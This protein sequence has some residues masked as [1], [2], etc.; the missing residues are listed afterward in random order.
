MSGIPSCDISEARGLVASPADIDRLAVVIGCSSA[1]SGL[2]PFY[3]SAESA[4]AGVG[5]GDAVDTLCQIIEQVQPDGGSV[6]IPAALYTVPATTAGS[7][8]AVD[9]SARYGTAAVAAH[10]ATHP[11]GTAEIYIRILTGGFVGTA[12]ITYVT[13]TDAGRHTS[14][15]KALGTQS[16]IV[17][18]EA[19]ARLD[20]SPASS[21]LT[22]LN[23]IINEEFGD[24][25]GHCDEG[26]TIHGTADTAG[27]VSGT[28]YPTA[29]DTATRVARINALRAAYEI[30]RVKE[31]GVHAV[32]D[33]VH[34]ITAANAVDDETALALALD[35]KAKLNAHESTTSPAVHGSADATNQVT[36][37]APSAGSLLAGDVIRVRTIAPAPASGDLTTA[38]AAIAASSADMG[39]IV[40]EFDCS[41]TL[42]STLTT[43]LSTLRA[44]GKMPL[45]LARTRVP[46]AETAETDAAW[47]ASVAADFLACYD[48]N[49]GVVASY[50][51]LT[52][53]STGNQYLRSPLA[54]VAADV[55][56]VSRA[57]IPDM[58]ADRMMANFSLVDAAGT[59]VGHDEG[60]RGASTGL[61]NETLG[62][63]FISTFRL[64]D[65]KRREEVYLT[66]PWVL[67]AADERIR[68]VPTRRLANA[69]KRVAISA[70]NAALGKHLFYIPATVSSPAMLTVPARNAIQ[71]SIRTALVAEFSSAEIDNLDDAAVETGLVQVPRAVTITGGNLIAMNS[72]I[73]PRIGGYLLHLSIVLAVQE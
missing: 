4:R 60:T 70:G 15:A 38:F 68:N 6:K 36:S 50:G 69:I 35:L 59:L 37:S 14:G 55:A 61:S 29:T 52:D 20:L 13:S 72:T 32:A 16:F 26:S 67:Y 65:P 25:N 7:Y 27:K 49:I 66:V 64:P 71:A 56:R 11:Y 45:M 44:A 47:N 5:Y 51:L 8:G 17:V 30:H 2:S 10:S 1:G 43:G 48:S 53:A 39:M 34:Y 57:D 33:T 41:G 19:N 23:T 73:A 22:G 9:V 58:P 3:L 42:A 28:T 12:G 40:A 21:D 62:N 46:D 31:S 63:R 18:A 54:Q 24:F